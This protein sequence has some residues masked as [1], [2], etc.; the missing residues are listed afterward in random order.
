MTTLTSDLL[1]S[2]ITDEVSGLP[3]AQR[4]AV[5][6]AYEQILKE[7]EDEAVKLRYAWPLYARDSQL[8]PDGDWD[9]WLILAG[10]GFG[11][12]RTGAEWVRDQVESKAAHRI[13]LV[14]RTTD[15]AQSVMIEGESGIINISPHWNMPTYEPSKRK[16]T[17]PNGAFALVFSSH[18]PDQ[19]RGPQFDAAW[20]D[21]LASWEYPEQTWDNLSFALRLGHPAT[22]RRHNH[23]QGYRAS[24]IT[25]QQARRTRHQRLHIRQPEQSAARLLQRTHR[26]VRRHPPRTAGDP[27]RAY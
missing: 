21:E 16:L 3:Y 19:L 24:P 13:A 15:E 14:A 6:R 12:T 27:R 22:I 26:P 9:T 2:E 18:E 10:R 5:V 20:C 4:M 8:P 11:K 25:S 17:W 1:I 23:T 7:H